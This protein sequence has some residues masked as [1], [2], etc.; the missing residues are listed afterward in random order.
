M[1]ADIIT[2]PDKET[3]QPSA[4][5]PKYIFT[6]NEI[7]EYRDAIN[8]HAGL[9]DA[10][11]TTALQEEVD[12]L[13]LASENHEDRIFVLE[14]V[15]SQPQPDI[16]SFAVFN[17]TTSKINL[18]TDTTLSVT[19]SY[20]E[21]EFYAKDLSTFAAG[22]GVI[23]ESGTNTSTLGLWTNGNLYIQDSLGTFLTTNGTLVSGF[24]QVAYVVR[25]EWNATDISVFLD[26]VFQKN[27]TKGDFVVSRLG[28]SYNHFG[29]KFN[30]GIGVL[31]YFDGTTTTSVD[32]PL[33]LGGTATDVDLEFKSSLG[34]L[35]PNV[36]YN[37]M[38]YE[39]DQSTNILNVYQNIG[40][41]RYSK[42]EIKR[43]TNLSAN[44]IYDVWT[45]VEADRMTYDGVDML[46]DGVQLLFDGGDSEFVYKRVGALDFVGGSYHGNETIINFGFFVNGMKIDTSVDVPLTACN[47]FYMR[48]K[49]N[50]H[51]ST[52]IVGHAIES[53]KDKIITLK[54]GGY[55]L[56]TRLTLSTDIEFDKV[57]VGLSCIGKDTAS[58]GHNEIG[59]L[60]VFAGGTGTLPYTKS[61]DFYFR[62]EA[63]KSS[64]FVTSSILNPI[65]ED[66]LCTMRVEDRASDSKYY[67]KYNPIG[68]IPSGTIYDFEMRV[69]FQYA[70]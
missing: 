3:F 20:L 4:L 55:K 2:S 37:T 12:D 36:D 65:T 46:G 33:L 16:D 19:G 47:E 22:L 59:E 62:N 25:L 66:A 68:L 15:D 7:N 27:I 32:N 67:K 58:E 60:A 1:P 56:G 10:V 29:T 53:V 13:T 30:G 31:S 52:D 51:D 54:N 45:I 23:G 69:T 26:G 38:Y 21:V 11:D 48:Q 6:A 49:S 24:S 35:D 8:N 42:I 41:D 43:K 14:N 18:T 64:S 9:I 5:D 28:S 39:F 50:I 70:G 34:G 40:K 63:N 61:K 17:G 44:N 57:F